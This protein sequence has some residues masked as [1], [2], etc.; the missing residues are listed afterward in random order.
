MSSEIILVVFLVVSFFLI[1]FSSSLQC[2]LSELN[3]IWLLIGFEA[4][5]EVGTLPVQRTVTL[6]AAA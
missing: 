2:L 3:E 5:P 6:A 1:I 4:Q